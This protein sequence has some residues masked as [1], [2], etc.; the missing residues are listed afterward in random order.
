MMP[1][2]KSSPHPA[3]FFLH[4]LHVFICLVVHWVTAQQKQ[5]PNKFHVNKRCRN[6]RK[7]TLDGEVGSD[8]PNGTQP[9]LVLA[10]LE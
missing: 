2:P 7:W 1:N 4:C 5:Q 6:F 9:Q 3:F 10:S 8:A